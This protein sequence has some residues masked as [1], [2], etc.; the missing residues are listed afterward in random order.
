M[1]KRDHERIVVLQRALKV[2]KDALLRIEHGHSSPHLVAENATYEIMQ[3]ETQARPT[4][5]AGLCGH[6]RPSR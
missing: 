6:E 4:P 5:L 3:I 1:S 2:A